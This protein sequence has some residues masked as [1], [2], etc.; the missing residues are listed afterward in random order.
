[1]ITKFI[2]S[3]VL[4]VRDTMAT[5]GFSGHL[6]NGLIMGMGFCTGL[7]GNTRWTY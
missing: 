4:E 3:G 2:I 1:M 7:R 5:L 6:S